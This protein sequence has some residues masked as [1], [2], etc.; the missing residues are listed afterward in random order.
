MGNVITD[1]LFCWYCKQAK[2]RHEFVPTFNKWGVK[3]GY[4]CEDCDCK[5]KQY[6]AMT[7][8]ERDNEI[9]GRGD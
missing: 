6:T 9:Q 4:K 7:P 1:T 5:S 3:T 2:P 8:E